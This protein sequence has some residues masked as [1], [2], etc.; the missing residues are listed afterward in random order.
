MET[1]YSDSKNDENNIQ[2]KMHPKRKTGATNKRPLSSNFASFYPHSPISSS[3]KSIKN[4]CNTIFD[5]QNYLISMDNIEY[6]NYLD[7]TNNRRLLMNKQMTFM[8]NIEYDDYSNIISN[9]HQLA[10]N[11]MFYTDNNCNQSYNGRLIKSNNTDDID[12][13]LES[14]SNIHLSSNTE[15]YSL[16]SLIGS[17]P[18]MDKNLVSLENT[19]IEHNE[20]DALSIKVKNFVDLIK[21]EAENLFSEI[22]Q[23]ST[24]QKLKFLEIILQVLKLNLKIKKRAIFYQSV[25]VFE[26]QGKVDYL[27][28]FY[29]KRFGC[30]QEDLNIRSGTKGICFGRV[31]IRF[32]DG[33]ISSTDVNDKSAIPD[34]EDVKSVDCYYKKILI[35][36]KEAIF[37]R[38]IQNQNLDF[39]V[40]CGKGYPCKNT[41]RFL[42]ML[43]AC[44]F[45]LTDFDP[46]GL[47]I[48][49]NYRRYVNLSRI[50]I[51]YEDIFNNNVDRNSCIKLNKYDYR[52]IEKLKK[53]DVSEEAKFIEGMGLKMEI[54]IVFNQPDFN[55]YEFFRSKGL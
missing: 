21:N 19:V 30:E 20:R 48:F 22:F 2:D 35:V 4:Q 36:E 14:L 40:V 41:I 49:M 37:D 38:I 53:D 28:K 55:I 31:N 6:D 29:T 33:N 47:H 13:R 25:P 34:M 51:G 3:S 7:I 1:R 44:L 46:F 32:H 52:M 24:L 5:S 42:K 10:N 39:L 27:I 54:E 16:R 8:D 23:K 26:N 45:C 50:G 18:Y 9:R 17:Q 15:V 43:D 11:Q 12:Q